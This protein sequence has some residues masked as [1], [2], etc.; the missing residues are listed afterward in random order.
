MLLLKILATFKWFHLGWKSLPKV[1][2]IMLH[3]EL[4]PILKR[5]ERTENLPYKY[6]HLKRR[7]NNGDGVM[8]K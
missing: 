8:Q 1:L 4:L 6:T 2:Y 5:T 3:L 7:P